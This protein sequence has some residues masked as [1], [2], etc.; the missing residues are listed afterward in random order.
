M[1][2]TKAIGRI[3]CK[4]LPNRLPGLTGLSILVVLA[5]TSNNWSV[6]KLGGRRW[7]LLHRLAYVAAIVLIYH[8]SIAG[9]GHWYISRWLLFLL[10]GLEA[11]RLIKKFWIRK[12]HTERA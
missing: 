6:R 7:K 1:C 11:A 10:V 9:K 3:C 4:V 12:T 8:Q 5:S 2:S